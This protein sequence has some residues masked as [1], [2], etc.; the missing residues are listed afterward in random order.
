[1]QVF[2]EEKENRNLGNK[3]GN[4]SLDRI[5]SDFYFQGLNGKL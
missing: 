4:C 2:A 5:S 1:M 3:I